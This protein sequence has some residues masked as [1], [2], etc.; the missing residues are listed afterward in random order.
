M[1]EN[2]HQA[3]RNVKCETLSWLSICFPACTP[4]C[5]REHGSL[6]VCQPT[7][8]QMLIPPTQ[9]KGR[10]MEWILGRQLTMSTTPEKLVLMSGRHWFVLKQM[11][12]PS[13]ASQTGW[14]DPKSICYL[15]IISENYK[16]VNTWLLVGCQVS[17]S[18][19][20][21]E[22][23]GSS[24]IWGQEPFLRVMQHGFRGRYFQ[25]CTGQQLG[26]MSGGYVQEC[27]MKG[28]VQN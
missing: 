18:G 23:Q 28:W 9:H 3:K 15:K 6:V 22:G 2:S 21:G 16:L 8:P 4:H 27:H 12:E 5:G 20:T 17:F 1:S 25:S 11:C 19:G 7:P 14:C 26:I 13:I 24:G 10:G